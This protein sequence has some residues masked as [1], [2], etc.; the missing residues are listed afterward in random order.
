MNSI[1]RL[2]FSDV[3][4]VETALKEYGENFW[5]KRGERSALKLFHEAAKRVPAY[6]DFLK[7][8]SI[9]PD[10]IKTIQDLQQVPAINKNNYLRCYPRDMLCWDGDFKEK[11]W[12][13]SATSGSTGE[14]FYFPRTDTQDE[15]YAFLAELYLRANF[16]IHE[17]STLY[18]NAFAMGVWIGGLFTYEA[19][20]KVSEKKEYRLSIINPGIN[21]Q[22]VINAVKNLGEEFDQ[23]I[24]GCYPP[25]FKDIIDLGVSSGL[26][27]E[28]Y[29]L[30][31]VFSAEGFNEQF[32]DYIL[33]T[34]KIQDVYKGTLNHYG[35]VDLGTMSHETPLTVLLRRN[36]LANE[37]IYRTLFGNIQ[38]LPTLTQ[39]LPELFYFEEVDGNLFCTADSGYP[40]VRYDLKDNGGVIK[41]TEVDTQLQASDFDLKTHIRNE[42]I[43]DTFWNL[44]M[45]YVYERTDFSVSFL[46]FQ[47]YPETIRKVLD[48][49]PYNKYFTGKCTLEVDYDDNSEQVLYIHIEQKVSAT[50]STT[51][52]QNRLL[53]AILMQLNNDNSEFRL[54][55]TDDPQKTT[56][57]IKIWPYEEQT[58][59]NGKGKQK[60]VKKKN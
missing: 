45:V 50:T 51:S 29:T 53:D 27:W 39:Y 20:K 41:L 21:K 46:G 12:V 13:V 6:Q 40:L 35:T 9:Q 34:A 15:Q 44:P 31:V 17:K 56:P 28:Q 5:I 7:K 3:E 57:V 36:A 58:Y 30:G 14:P 19:I 33:Q 49:P 52:I 4:E 54:N 8:N 23:V 60:W 22:E 24:I 55:Y 32:R 43:E 42:G 16:R 38:K 25:V 59:F 37:T 11:S 26:D 18:I 1:Q 2:G 10:K 48:S 47:I